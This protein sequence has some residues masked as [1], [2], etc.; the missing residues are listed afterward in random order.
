MKKGNAPLTLGTADIGRLLMQYAA[1]AVIAMT[2]A[3]LYN[4]TDSIFIGHGV[5]AMALSGLTVSFPLMNLAAAF[6][7]LVGMGGA[8]LLSLRLGQKDY[9]SANKI[10]GNVLV[11][12]IIVG[13]L[14]SAAAFAF[15][16]PMLYFFGASEHT[17]RY[18]RDFMTIILAG[19]VITHIYMGLN[20]LLR[21]SGN[22]QK[23]MYATIFTII[24]NIVLNPLFIFGFG[25]GIRGSALATVISQ[26]VVLI[27]QFQFFA[28]KENFIHLRKGIYKL[29]SE[30]VKGIISIGLAPF[31]L[32][33]AACVI[34][35]L[36][37][38]QLLFYGGELGELAVGA[39]GIV[40]R[41]A[42][43]FAM[44]VFGINQGMQPIAGYNYGASLYGRVAE[45]LKKTIF[46]STVVM[47]TG[48]LTVELFPHAVASVFTTD[49]ELVD[50]TVQGL[51]YVFAAFP[52]IGLQ[53][54]VSM[55]FQS[56]GKAVKTIFLSVTRQ[57]FFLI[58]MVVIL[59]KYFGITGIWMS[60][61]F[62]DFIS[63]FTAGI[64][65][66]MQFREFKKQSSA[67]KFQQS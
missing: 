58:P 7:S 14:F 57:V 20:A 52:L 51:R 28:D 35:V 42:F 56:I 50:L 49:K 46:F 25:W 21:S 66:W 40:N 6:G 61:P 59:P 17:I 29:K 5:G 11:L 38:R 64:L 45:V 26:A 12:N 60:M 37:N 32:N 9:D 23:A 22:P 36:I 4:I 39:Y 1:P 15:L 41:V 31:L 24:I 44:I 67:L 34:V 63:A 27:W 30:V 54:V 43:L 53:M 16:E 65:L 55:F 8:A 33:A 3:S 2:A 48:F 19:N 47:I 13:L 10:L 62:S 18:A